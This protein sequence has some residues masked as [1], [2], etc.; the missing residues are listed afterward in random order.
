M[1]KGIV[2][3]S[4][5]RHI[6]G[7]PVPQDEHYKGVKLGPI[8]PESTVLKANTTFFAFTWPIGGTI[9][10]V[11]LTQK[12]AISE[13]PPLVMVEQNIIEFNFNPFDHHQLAAG[14]EDGSVKVFRVPEGGLTKNQEEPELVLEGAHSK[15]ILN[16]EYHPLSAG[17]LSTVGADNEIKLWDLAH[18]S[19]KLSLPNVHKG[20]ITCIAWNYDGSLL[21]T[22]CKDKF[23]RIFDPRGNS[24]IGE[25]ADHQGA[26]SSRVIWHGKKK[27]C[28]YNWFY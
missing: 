13:E 17:L 14:C 27:S 4:K 5:F 16:V 25:I 2:R 7:T 6:F 1:Q 9:C 20:I 18:S 3:Q 22:S 23:L 11:P 19:P 24:L 12:G 8:S 21:A 28:L 26:K 15:R 10:V